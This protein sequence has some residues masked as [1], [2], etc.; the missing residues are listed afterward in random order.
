M[1]QGMLITTREKALSGEV[2][3]DKALYCLHMGF[4]APLYGQ[5]PEMIVV[6]SGEKSMGLLMTAALVVCW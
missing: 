6:K 4:G 2:E 1:C 3:G 5:H